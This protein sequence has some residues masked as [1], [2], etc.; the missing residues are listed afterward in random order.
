MT[1]TSFWEED[2]CSVETASILDRNGAAEMALL[3]VQTS[4]REA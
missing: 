3:D 1:S 4:G 2:V